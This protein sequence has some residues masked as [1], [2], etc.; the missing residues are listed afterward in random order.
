VGG[1]WVDEG[2]DEEIEDYLVRL[3]ACAS[4]DAENLEEEVL[5]M[6]EGCLK[7]VDSM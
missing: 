4:V 2:L 1:S 7:P 5:V 6:S 3:L